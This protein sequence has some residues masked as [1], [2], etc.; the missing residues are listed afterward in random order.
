MLKFLYDEN[1]EVT[2]PFAEQLL[3]VGQ[4]VKVLKF[5]GNFIYF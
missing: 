5:L 4:K 1:F 3:E 2:Q